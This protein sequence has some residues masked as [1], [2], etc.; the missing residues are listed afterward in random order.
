M[1]SY[2]RDRMAVPVAAIY[3]ANASGKSNLLDGFHFMREAV[4]RSLGDWDAEGGVPRHPY[5]LDAGAQAELSTYVIEMVIESVPYMYGFT[6]DDERV[7]EEWLYSYPEKRRRLLFERENDDFKFGT[8]LGESKGKLQSLQELTR[9]NCLFLSA[10]VQFGIDSFMPVYHW[11]RISFVVGRKSNFLR[12][13]TGRLARR[14]ASYLEAGD[15]SRR[16]LVGLV[17][18]AD[19]G[20]TDIYVEETEDPKHVPRLER[21]LRDANE[22]QDADE[23]SRISQQIEQV[24]AD[25]PRT[26]TEVK[27]VHGN[28]SR[29][30]DIHDE[31]AGTQAWFELLPDVLDALDRGRVLL[32][33]EIDTSLHP[34]LT[35]RLVGLFQD[36]QTKPV[37]CAVDLH[38]AR[39]EPT[40]HDD[41]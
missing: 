12:R 5:R 40:G 1:P 22:R 35:S 23:V 41:G 37:R 31:S 11:F 13:S 8:K 7:R 3:G 34:L 18:A 9:G 6:V 29:P 38:H 20:I 17:S 14:I 25:G 19:S 39:H 15:A 26:M 36:E 21:L 16:M 28:Y 2:D 32:V 4:L 24:R 30:F 27:M 10:A 33:D